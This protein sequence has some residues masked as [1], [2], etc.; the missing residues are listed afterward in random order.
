[1]ICQLHNKLYDII[2]YILTG[3]KSSEIMH[4]DE[5]TLNEFSFIL[6]ISTILIVSLFWIIPLRMISKPLDKITFKCKKE[7]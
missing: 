3:D 2:G 6:F 4:K 5:I 7:K 1:M